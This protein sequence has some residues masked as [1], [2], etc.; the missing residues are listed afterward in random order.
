MVSIIKN[1]NQI[2]HN[3][4]AIFCDLWGCIHNGRESFKEGLEALLKF[5]NSGGYV[6]LVTNAPRPSEFVTGF[7]DKLGIT[8]KFYDAIVTSGDATKFSV[9]TGDFGYDIYH[10]GPTRDL[11]FFNSERNSAPN[12]STIN[13]VSMS[14]ASSIICTGLFNDQTE[15]PSDYADIIKLGVKNKLPLLCANPDIQVDFGSQRLWCAGAIAERYTKAGGESIY[16]GKPHKP[17]YELS[18]SKLFEIN[19]SITK[20]EIICVGD[21]LLTDILGGV[22][23]GLDTLFV[24]G[25]LSGQDTGVIDGVKSPSQNKLNELFK[26]YDLN[27]TMSIG[28]FQ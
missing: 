24:A 9:Q 16:F 17:I 4:K 19:P 10:I 8:K 25:G 18:M 2:A 3:Y 5:R 11:C 20:K 6:I 27:P 23:H 12:S 1:F 28:Y 22:S 14:K 7:L 15:T 13:L 21:G 26:K